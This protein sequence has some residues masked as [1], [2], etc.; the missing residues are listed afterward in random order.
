[1][2]VKD[3]WVGPASK[4][5]TYRSYAGVYVRSKPSSQLSIETWLFPTTS[6]AVVG[7]KLGTDLWIDQPACCG[8]CQEPFFSGAV[9]LF[10]SVDDCAKGCYA[11]TVWDTYGLGPCVDWTWDVCG[12]LVSFPLQ[13]VHRFESSWL[14]DMSTACLWQSSHR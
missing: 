13:R 4:Y 3:R 12:V 11:L 1:V 2:S 7:E 5:W 10:K 14:S 6:L 9:D 8:F